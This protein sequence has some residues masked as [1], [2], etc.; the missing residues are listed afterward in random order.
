MH[1]V[2]LSGEYPLW[3][4]GGVGTFIQT[5]GRSLME[6]GHKVSVVGPGTGKEELKMHDEG[7]QIYRLP[8]NN[9]FLPNFVYNAYQ[10]NKKLKQL[11]KEDPIT[12][13]EAAEGGLALLAKSHPAKKVIR[14][15]GGH[16][17]FS[18]AEK[19]QINWRKGWLE[20]RSFTKADGFIAISQ[21]VKDHTSKYLSYG[22]RPTAII[23]LPL[24]TS[25]Q[26]PLV[27]I[28]KDHILFAGTVCEKKGVRQLIEAF[29][30]VR[31]K[32]PDKILDIFGREWFYPDG[33]SYHQML[34]EKYDDS[35]FEN[36]NF[37]GSISRG[38]LD[39]KY[40]EAAFC[41]FPSHMET[42]GLVSIE[43]MLLG[44]PVIF[45]KYGPGPETVTHQKT[46][47]LCD[48]HKPSDIAEKMIWCIEHPNEAAALGETASKWVKTRFDAN[49]ILKSNVQF[50][51]SLIEN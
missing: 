43:A 16:H 45:S 13:I 26:T 7:I 3:T 4:S 48:V 12:I 17:F 49:T 5:F 44:K 36:V 1:I 28:K 50:Y 34:T 22:N 33:S 37:H 24:D 30:L 32:Y 46:G 47:L 42:Q 51:Q 40:A 2:F 14:L 6:A 41:V 15:H 31:Q 25:K 21:Y 23:N 10:I 35:Y 11:H 8:K 38:E 39:E 18:E 20:K 27:M 19:R 9:G 29:K